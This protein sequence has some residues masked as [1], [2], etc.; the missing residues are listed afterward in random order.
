MRLAAALGAEP[1][2]RIANRVV[3]NQ[4]LIDIRPDAHPAHDAEQVVRAVLDEIVADGTCVL[5]GTRWHGKPM[6]RASVANH[7]TTA[8]DIDLTAE[9][10]V[11]A[12]H[13][14]HARH[15]LVPDVVTMME[16]WHGH[17]EAVTR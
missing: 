5:G 15:G 9:A 2:I 10:V 17:V 6:L 11:R 3:Y 8:R 14:V 1:G 13:R 7:T 4:V 12:V 16:P